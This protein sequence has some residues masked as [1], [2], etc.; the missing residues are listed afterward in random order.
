[1]RPLIIGL[2]GGSGSGKS[3]LAKALVEAMPRGCLHLLYDRYYRTLTE[4]QRLD[5]DKVNFDHPET[6]ETSRLLA[7]LESLLTTGAALVPRYDFETHR[8]ESDERVFAEP[9]VVVEGILTLSHPELSARMDVRLYVD[10]PESV[11][12][13]R[14]V[15][16]DVAERGRTEAEV[17]HRFART[18]RP[19]HEQFV[20]PSK[21][22]AHL[23]LD[24][25]TA[26]AANVQRVLEYLKGLE[27]EPRP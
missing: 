22:E 25:T 18:V 21:R 27:G 1:M 13:G 26:I 7:D 3:T 14:R 24:G 16:R 11:R 17:R 4:T 12:L 19:M 23:L 2:A 9:V 15:R 6:L 5:V 10:A 20:E 8:R